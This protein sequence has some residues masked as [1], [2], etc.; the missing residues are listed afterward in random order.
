MAA[1]DDSRVIRQMNVSAGLTPQLQ[2]RSLEPN[3]RQVDVTKTNGTLGEIKEESN[4]KNAAVKKN[5]KGWI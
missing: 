4:T 3:V 1:P 2:G 5:L